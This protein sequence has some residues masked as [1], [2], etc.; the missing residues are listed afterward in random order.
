MIVRPRPGFFKLLFVVRGTI[1]P[2]VLPHVLGVAALASLV[3][4]TLKQG[5]LRLPVTSPAPLSLLGIALSIFLG[6]R[7]NACYDRWWEGRK[8]WGALII[9]V[10]AFTHAAIALL[11]DGT[12]ELPVAG[13][14]AARRLVHR[15]IAFPYALAAH[16]RGQ[17]A[18]EDIGLYVSEPERSRV[19][20]SGNRPNALLREHQVELARLLRE[21]RLTDIT[22]AALNERVHVMMS[23]FTACERIRLTPLPFAYTV[24]LHRTAY[25]FCL[26]LPFGLAESMG[27]FTPVLSAMIAYTFFGLDLLSEELEEPFGNTPNDLPLLAMSRTAEINMLEALG[28]PQPEPLRPKDFILG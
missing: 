2:R 18:T 27:W 23:V 26:L 12:A 14:Q 20:A 22:W 9:E 25:L 17:D 24:L 4:L 16:L 28:E 1:L 11:D 6:F 19:L 21:G 10:R 8:Q 13:R 3:V 5:Y 7:N 15:T